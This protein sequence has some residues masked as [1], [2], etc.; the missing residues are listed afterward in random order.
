MVT[1]ELLNTFWI[2]SAAISCIYL[3]STTKNKEFILF[4]TWLTASIIL[5]IWTKVS[6]VLI[7]PT[8][9]ITFVLMFFQKKIKRKF[10]VM[11]ALIMLTL[12]SLFSFPI[13]MRNQT[14][15]NASNV[16]NMVAKK[17]YTLR[18]LDFYFRLDWIPKIDMYNTQYYSLLGAAWNSFWTDG[19]NA[20]TPFIKFHKKSFVL[21]SL[22][23]L[24]LPL[25]IL[26]L[27]NFSRKNK[28][29]VHI[30]NSIGLTMIFVY[31]WS[32]LNGHYS[33]LRLTY[34][35][36]IVIPYA[37]GITKASENKKLKWPILLLLFI[38]FCTM[39]SF[40]WILPWWHVTK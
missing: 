17:E 35:M 34:E 22:G 10:V 27:I 7:A 21:W 16:V 24:L 28:Q 33:G 2:T 31:I 9:F 38:Q 18:T 37:F 5:G 11:G 3:I 32:N 8:I 4:M 15:P 40:Y 39:V 19:H 25:A 26:G 1:N 36:G 30:I 12:V 14:I 29:Y 13:L 20:I 6:I 23:F